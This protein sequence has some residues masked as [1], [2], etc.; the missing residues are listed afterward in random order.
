MASDTSS[1]IWLTPSE[2]EEL[3]N[4][5][6]NWLRVLRRS[7]A[8]KARRVEFCWVFERESLEQYAREHADRHALLLAAKLAAK[9]AE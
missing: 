7:G 2:A 6:K 3:T 4:Y 8:V 1:S 5:S 9:G